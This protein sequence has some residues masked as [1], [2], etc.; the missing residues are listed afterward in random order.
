M[1]SK[2]EIKQLAE[3]F[4]NGHWLLIK[5]KNNHLNDHYRGKD[6]FIHGYTQCQ[7]DTIHNLLSIIEEYREK[8]L[9]NRNKPF[10]YEAEIS[11]GLD[12]LINFI[13]TKQN[14]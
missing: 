10:H 2:E 4:T 8:E 7:Q 12:G 14:D 5:I 1:K 13:K 11:A 9:P 6:A 3:E